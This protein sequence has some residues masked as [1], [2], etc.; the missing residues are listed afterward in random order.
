[1]N[2]IENLHKAYILT[3]IGDYKTASELARECMQLLS[4]SVEIRR[5]VKEVLKK[6]D[7][8]YKISKKLREESINTTDLIQVA[9]YYL[10]KRLSVKK[11]NDIEIIEK[12]N[13]KLSVIEHLLV[14]EVR[15][16]CEGC[17]GYKYSLLTS[18]KGYLILYDEIIYAEFFEG[19]KDD[20]INEILKNTKL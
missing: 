5:K 4:D 10:A 12:G 8:E 9:L 2:C 3:W 18:A 19:N 7:R 16:Y 13:I 11:D 1:M 20:V 14:K 17:R 6:A 15:G